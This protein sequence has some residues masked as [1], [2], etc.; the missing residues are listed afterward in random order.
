MQAS[1]REI[2]SLHIPFYFIFVTVKK[3]HHE[4][5]A[6]DGML[7]RR[8][9]KSATI[10]STTSAFDEYNTPPESPDLNSM[11]LRS[12]SK[13]ETP[14]VEFD[15]DIKN[16]ENNDQSEPPVPPPRTRRG[17]ATKAA[18]AKL[19]DLHIAAESLE[20]AANEL[21]NIGECVETSSSAHNGDEIVKYLS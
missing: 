19:K 6:H 21:L 4:H 5:V 16:K 13:M 15:F 2:D 18:K 14:S 11:S 12:N 20:I 3:K 17:L 9:Q 10:K 8:K 7:D 1:K